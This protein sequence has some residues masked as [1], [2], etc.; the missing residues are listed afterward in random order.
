VNDVSQIL[1]VQSY[2]F[3]GFKENAQVIDLVKKIGLSR[4]ELCGVHADFNDDK[5]FDKVIAQYADGGVKIVSIGVQGFANQPG[6][7][8]KWFEFA[9]KAGAKMISCSYDLKSMPECLPASAKLADEFDINLGIHNHGGWDWL[10]NSNMLGHIFANNSKRIGLCLDT[11]WMLDSGEDPIK[12]ADR[13]ADRLYGV[14]IKDF[15]FN[16]ARKPEDVVVGTGNLDLPKLVEIIKTK[17]P[18]GCCPILEYEGDVN[19][20]APALTQCVE[21]VRAIK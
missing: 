17:A 12:I 8:R 11:A 15:V 20:P 1:A 13:F 19:N 2:C 10:G 9:K 18:A 14:H 5:T 16:R 6:K 3:R 7:E 4:I 21:K